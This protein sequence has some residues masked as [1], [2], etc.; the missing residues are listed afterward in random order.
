[1]WPG[2]PGHFETQWFVLWSTLI[3]HE[4]DLSFVFEWPS[5]A[6]TTGESCTVMQSHECAFFTILDYVSPAFLP[7]NKTQTLSGLTS[8]RTRLPDYIFDYLIDR[9]PETSSAIN[10]LSFCVQHVGQGFTTKDTCQKTVVSRTTKGACTRTDEFLGMC[11]PEWRV[12]TVVLPGLTDIWVEKGDQR[13]ER[14]A[15]FHTRFG[16]VTTFSSLSETPR[17]CFQTD[18]QCLQRIHGTDRDMTPTSFFLYW[19]PAQQNLQTENSQQASFCCVS[20]HIVQFRWKSSPKNQ[21][22]RAVLHR[23]EVLGHPCL[24][25]AVCPH[26]HK[27]KKQTFV[28]GWRFEWNR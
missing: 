16:L 22:T 2:Y 8:I 19:S 26:N 23:T 7:C 24:V 20:P 6:Q 3:S 21:I 17:C 1:M 25:S 11:W 5:F 18:E 12:I 9:W 15:R 13:W 10:S 4:V 27:G 14:V 28:H